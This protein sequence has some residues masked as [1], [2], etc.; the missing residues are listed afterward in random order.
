MSISNETPADIFIEWLGAD[1]K[2][3]V[4]DL[5]YLIEKEVGKSLNVWRCDDGSYILKKLDGPRGL[6]PFFF[7]ED[8]FFAEYEKASFC[9]IMGNNE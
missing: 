8:V 7:V 3:L 4:S 5:E 6:A 9:Y 1:D 2:K